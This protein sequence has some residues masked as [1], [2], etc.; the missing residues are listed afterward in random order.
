MS[1]GTKVLPPSPG[2]ECGNFFGNGHTLGD[3]NENVKLDL[4]Q[5]NFSVVQVPGKGSGFQVI[6]TQL[7]KSL[8]FSFQNCWVI[9]SII[10]YWIC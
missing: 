9:S 1:A 10:F 6:W 3:V 8:E 7:E 4:P 2:L 5:V